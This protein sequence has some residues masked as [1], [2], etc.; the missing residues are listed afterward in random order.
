PARAQARTA[1]GAGREGTTARARRETVR[2]RRTGAAPMRSLRALL[3]FL[4]AAGVFG[5]VLVAN[6]ATSRAVTGTT[7]GDCFGNLNQT[8]Y[9]SGFQATD[10]TKMVAAEITGGGVQLNTNLA[11]L[12]AQHIILPFDQ[13]LQVKY[14]YRNAA[15]SQT[16]GWFYFDQLAAYLDK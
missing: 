13:D 7:S 4:P 1:G 3:L 15:A 2:S 11:P 8:T 6:H 12:D 5:V 16:L 9:T 14:V 10:F